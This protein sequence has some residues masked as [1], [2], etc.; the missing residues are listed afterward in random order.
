MAPFIKPRQEALEIRRILSVFLAQNIRNPHGELVSATSLVLPPEGTQVES[1]APQLTGIRRSYLQALQAHI[2]ARE[3]YNQLSMRVEADTIK[4]K[5]RNQREIEKHDH[6]SAPTFHEFLYEQ[7]RY[8]KLI[9]LR[10]SLELLANKDAAKPDYL[11]TE[12]I[13]ETCTPPPELPPT[14]STD[15]LALV[16][17]ET[18][19]LVSTLEK[20]VLRAQNA[21]EN[22]KTLL[23]KAKEKYQCKALTEA[24][25][26]R[27]SALHQTRDE[28][29][30]WLE[31]RL[32][33]PTQVDDP[34]E[35]L[36]M[37]IPEGCTLDIDQRIK[38]IQEKYNNYLEARKT[39]LAFMSDRR[40]LAMRILP[41]LQEESSIPRPQTSEIA[42]SDQ[43]AQSVLPIITQYLIPAANEQ[44]NFHQHESH[45]SRSLVNE[46]QETIRTLEILAEESHLLSKYQPPTPVPP[47][48][49][50]CAGLSSK[51]LHSQELLR[52]R[53]AR[54]VT[55]VQG[56]ASAASAARSLQESTIEDSLRYGEKEAFTAKNVLRELQGMLGFQRDHD[57]AEGLELKIDT[58]GGGSRKETLSKETK[59]SKGV[60]AG[61][62]GKLGIDDNKAI[63]RS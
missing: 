47:F 54:T 36:P 37:S 13:M 31:V 30:E 8:Q 1:I 25:N 11:D 34:T 17:D 52:S 45:L 55:Q 19:S 49:K 61:L 46:E 41:V 59:H 48:Q 42:K 22:E 12:S 28:L 21:F 58:R 38:N 20:A 16:E 18:Q 2:A 9:I 15:L 60:W 6:I 39:L 43:E 29:I 7:R 3:S 14:Y 57:K 53:E 5:R 23:T 62:N 26:T 33:S 10:D 4:V 40:G 50:A 63:E 51:S 24:A 56:W 32:A 35:G 27:I 44:A